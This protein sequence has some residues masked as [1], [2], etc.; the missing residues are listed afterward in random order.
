MH[1]IGRTDKNKIKIKTLGGDLIVSF[2]FNGAYSDITLEGSVKQVF[3]GQIL[4]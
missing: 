2:K 3:K 1:N 4:I